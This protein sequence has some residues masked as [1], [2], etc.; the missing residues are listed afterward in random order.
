MSQAK[1]HIVAVIWYLMPTLKTDR[2]LGVNPCIEC[3]LME[4]K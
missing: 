4:L 2:Y 3:R 1:G